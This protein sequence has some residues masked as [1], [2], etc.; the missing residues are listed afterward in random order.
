MKEEMVGNSGAGNSETAQRYRDDAQGLKTG[1]GENWP[2]M[3]KS[4]S[5][6]SFESSLPN[7]S[8]ESLVSEGD[9]ACKRVGRGSIL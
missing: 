9:A 7:E 6:E 2:T 3:P 4:Q 5:P 8:P 1:G